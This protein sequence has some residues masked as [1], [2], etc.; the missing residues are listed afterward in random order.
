MVMGKKDL[1]ICLA[2]VAFTLLLLWG[3][4]ST[5]QR[6]PP[7]QSVSQLGGDFLPVDEAFPE[8]INTV[9]EGGFFHEYRLSRDRL[10]S[11]QIEMLQD[12]IKNSQAEAKSREAA[13]IRLVEIAEAMEKE[14]KA[15]NLIKA[16]GYQECVVMVQ[17]G[18]TTV[19]VQSPPMPLQQSKRVK[20]LVSR[21]INSNPEQLSLVTRGLP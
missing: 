16:E 9:P 8:A 2:A 10:R 13:G 3:G 19:V 12:V 20:E 21:A 14:L 7:V 1:L 11:K 17:A 15:E 4:I 6:V 5:M 18:S